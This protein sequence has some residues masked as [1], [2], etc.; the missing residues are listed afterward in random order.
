MSK[1]SKH[2][3]GVRAGHPPAKKS[4]KPH[5]PAAAPTSRKRKLLTLLGLLCFCAALAGVTYALWPTTKLGRPR[6]GLLD[7]TPLKLNPDTPPGPAPEGMVWVRGGEFWMGGEVEQHNGII[8]EDSLPP[9]KVYVDGFFMDKYEVTNEQWAVF[10][11]ETGYLTVAELKPDPNDFTREQLDS[12]TPEHKKDLF[13]HPVSLVFTPPPQ[14]IYNLDIAHMEHMWWSVVKNS[15]WKQPEGPMGSIEGKE[16]RPATHIAWVDAV[17]YCKWLSKKTGRTYRLPTEAEWEFAARGG[18]NQKDYPWGDELTP[19]GKW[20][21]NIWQGRFPNENSEA[22]GFA[23]AAPVGSFPANGYGLHDMAGNVWE[24]CSDFY[25]KDYYKESPKKNPQGPT[26]SFDL[27]EPD[28]KE[29]YVQRGGSFLCADNYCIRFQVAARGKGEKKSA[30][31]HV[32]FRTV[33]EAK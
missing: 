24:W 10:A 17:E 25:R 5:T 19:D 16:K 26:S 9:H 22:D 20:M 27:L 21:A 7:P 29:K 15:S 6:V 32:G 2:E 8:A 30:G 13:A 1:H 28:A 14:R 3:T 33:C 31:N 18:L 4:H 11:K 12:M 23:R